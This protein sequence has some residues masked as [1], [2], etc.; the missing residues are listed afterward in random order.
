M[1]PLFPSFLL[2]FL[3]GGLFFQ[4]GLRL[5]EVVGHEAGGARVEA[6]QGL[7]LVA[8][9]GEGGARLLG[10]HF[11]QLHAPLVER[12]D[13]PHEA[14]DGNAVFVEAEELAEHV[15][16]QVGDEDGH[17][18]PVAGEGHVR[19]QVRRHALRRAL[20]RGLAV[21]EGVGLGEEVGHELVVA[22]DHLAL[23]AERVLG[24]ARRDELGRDR[25]ALVHELVEGV[26]AVG[27]GLAE[28]DLARGEGH[29]VAVQV[30]KLA[31]RLHVHLLNVGGE[32][33]EGLRVREHGAGGVAQEAQ[34]P[35]PEEAHQHRDVGVQGGVEKM[36]V[37]RTRPREHLGQEVVAVLEAQGHEA[38]GGA[39]A[40]AA[41]DPV[42]KLEEAVLADPEVGHFGRGRL[43]GAG[44]HVR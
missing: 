26:L 14:L 38:G 41:A 24:L 8:G 35:D 19:L 10:Q 43:R 37:H 39:D 11:A 27:A 30:H 28:D 15:R 40:V 22:G 13:V 20:F 4:W 12:V 23:A 36:H 33:A 9:A 1:G 25:R 29:H 21:G 18:G 5:G 34:V 32:L 17:G 42:P 7:G 44:H 31:V 3:L 16:A 6:A 2:F